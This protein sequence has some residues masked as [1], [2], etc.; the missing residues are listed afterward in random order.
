MKRPAVGDVLL[1][2][3]LL[4]TSDIELRQL[5]GGNSSRQWPSLTLETSRRSSTVQSTSSSLG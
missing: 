2:L 1:G 5:L 4:R 3:R